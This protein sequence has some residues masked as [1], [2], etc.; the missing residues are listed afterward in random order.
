MKPAYRQLSVEELIA[1]ESAQDY[2]RGRSDDT[3]WAKARRG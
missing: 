3:A 1:E 2:L